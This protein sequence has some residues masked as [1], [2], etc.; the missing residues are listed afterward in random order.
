VIVLSHSKNYSVLQLDPTNIS[1]VVLH[2]IV[3]W[4]IKISTVISITLLQ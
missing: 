4:T 3:T 2:L 1:F